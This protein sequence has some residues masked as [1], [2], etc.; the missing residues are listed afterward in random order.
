MSSFLSTLREIVQG[1][2]QCM[3][4]IMHLRTVFT[5][6]RTSCLERVH[7]QN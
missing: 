1:N 3:T 2:S 6:I 7:E 5:R 4:C